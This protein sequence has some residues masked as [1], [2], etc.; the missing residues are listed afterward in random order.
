VGIL[1]AESG[2]HVSEF[3]AAERTYHLLVDAANLARP[4]ST[5][6]RVI[7]QTRLP[8]HHAVQALISGDPDQFYNEEFTARRLL[9]YPP[10]C[11]LAELSITG[12]DLGVVE[13][14]AKR[15]SAELEQN[16]R[17]QEPL[18]ILGPV[19]AMRRPLKG[20]QQYRILVKGSPLTALSRRIHDS[21]QTMEREYRKG[22]IKFV[23]DI[24]PIENG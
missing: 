16:A 9:H 15:W 4:A 1:Q 6:G 13:E 22:R 17:D 21:V 14:A 8:T 24:D 23:V 18:I 2:L 11:H 20:R 19:P 5:G 10:A 3:R 12:K 7:V